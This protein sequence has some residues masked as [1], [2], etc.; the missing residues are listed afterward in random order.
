VF[1]TGFVVSVVGVVLMLLSTSGG[2]APN[3][4]FYT[5]GELLGA[6]GGAIVFVS[7]ILALVSSA[8]LGRWGWFAVTLIL[9][10]IGLLPL[11]MII[12]SLAGPTQ[13]RALRPMVA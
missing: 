5:V 4:Q 2:P 1:V 11:V 9:G 8:I 3:S 7:W 13:R 6:F 12:Y 10:L